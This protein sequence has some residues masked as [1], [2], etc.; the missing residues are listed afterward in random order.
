[1]NAGTLIIG[2]GQAGAHAASTLRGLTYDEPITLVGAEPWG[3]YHRPPLSKA[4]LLGHAPTESLGIRSDAYFHDNRIAL[5]SGEPIYEV[6]L[7]TQ[8]ARAENGKNYSFDKLVLATGVAPMKLT[9]PGAVLPG[10]MYL[11]DLG[12]AIALRARLAYSQHLVI[13]GG[14]YIGLE[15]AASARMLGKTVTVV[16]MADRLL[17][18]VAPPAIGDFFLAQHRQR[19]VNVRLGATLTRFLGSDDGVT[20]AELSDGRQIQADAVVIGIGSR[21]QSALARQMGLSVLPSGAIEVDGFMQTSDERVLAIG[22]CVAAPDPA[23]RHVRLQVPSVQNALNQ[24][25]IAAATIAGKPQANK[26]IPWFWSDQY[27]IKLQ[28]VGHGVPHDDI[29]VRGDPDSQRFSVFSYC[30]DTLASA[31]VINRPADFMQ[32]KKCI[33]MGLQIDK[34]LIADESTSIADIF[35]A[36]QRSPQ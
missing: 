27:D 19:G 14:G 16:E 4:F 5:V 22:D 8:S 12:D 28:I 36:H 20:A 17:K 33:E 30:G 3:P 29:V 24:A 11:G 1:M 2:A 13:V 15:L 23:G 9:I 18:R 6:D 35:K 25:R 26:A 32:V 31:S 10:V 34:K 21:P 7:H